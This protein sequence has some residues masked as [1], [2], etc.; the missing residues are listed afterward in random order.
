MQ[1]DRPPES[2]TPGKPLAH[3]RQVRS[4]RQATIIGLM[5]FS[6]VMLMLSLFLISTSVRNDIGRSE[7][8]LAAIQKRLIR[9][10]TPAPELEE[11]LT[12]LTNTMG[13]A[14]K[15]EAARPPLGVNWPAIVAVIGNYNPTVLRL[16]S[17][18]QI[19][20]RITMTGRAVDDTIVVEYVRMLEESDLFAGVVLQS[21]TL[22]TPTTPAVRSAPTAT[23]TPIAVVNER[24]EFVIVFE[25]SV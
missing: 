7:A 20:N 22:I 4:L 8:N 11:L 6:L 12:T 17:L 16:T 13:L 24:V 2:V 21:L 19:D 25:L 15:L 3:I 23:P 5:V 10:S 1:F 18:I 14:D 9:L